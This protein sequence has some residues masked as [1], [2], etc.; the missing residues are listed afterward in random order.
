M[1]GTG[2]WVLG[3]GDWMLEG[4]GIRFKVYGGR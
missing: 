1:L 2:Y 4:N 3:I